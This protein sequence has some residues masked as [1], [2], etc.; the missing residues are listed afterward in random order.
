MD[1]ICSII[2]R[3]HVGVD[4]RSE[5]GLPIGRDVLPVDREEGALV[6]EVVLCPSIW[7]LLFVVDANG[8]HQL[9][10]HGPS[11]S[12]GI[13]PAELHQ[14]CAARGPSKP[15]DR[16]LSASTDVKSSTVSTKL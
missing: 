2:L 16:A 5:L 15:S 13:A 1:I 10:D 3:A 14:C 6:D 8:V 9:M 11:I 4:V 7:T 12:H